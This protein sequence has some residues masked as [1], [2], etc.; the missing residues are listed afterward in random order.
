[1]IVI[2][3]PE[4]KEIIY[5]FSIDYKAT[6]K[7]IKHHIDEYNSNLEKLWNNGANK[8][9]FEIKY[10]KGQTYRKLS[11]KSG[12][13]TTV[14]MALDLLAGHLLTNM[15]TKDTNEDFR[16]SNKALVTKKHD[17]IVKSTA[18]RHVK[19]ALGCG[20]FTNKKFN[21]TKAGYSISWNKNLLRFNQNFDFN[22]VLVEQYK[23]L[24]LQQNIEAPINSLKGLYA[25]K[26]KGCDL[27]GLGFSVAS[28]NLNYTHLLLLEHKINIQSG[29]VNIIFPD[30]RQ[31][32]SI[33]NNFS[34]KS[35]NNECHTDTGTSPQVARAPHEVTEIL[36]I[37]QICEIQS[38]INI[39]TTAVENAE[40][41]KK[42]IVKAVDFE[43]ASL[44]DV[45]WHH[46][47]RVYAFA[48]TALY[49]DRTLYEIDRNL[50]CLQIY[51]QFKRAIQNSKAEDVRTSVAFHASDFLSRILLTKKYLDKNPF[52]NQPKPAT[53]FDV[54][55]N[56]CFN[57]TA[58]WLT[59]TNKMQEKNKE[60]LSHYKL[61]IS[62]YNEYTKNPCVKTF[63]SGQSRLSK[64]K[65]KVWQNMFNECIVN[66]K[67]LNKRQGMQNIRQTFYK[68]SA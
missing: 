48:I 43:N 2:P 36:E 63:Q 67:D 61:L 18:F 26:I 24:L 21:G 40:Q 44:D 65:N 16:I 47:F 53:Y 4:P 31:E 46:V 15:I 33:N 22:C 51:H 59:K 12:E 49:P 35:L 58:E 7:A 39:A 20:L 55:S 13:E 25:L 10:G 41:R 50:G 11:F 5:Y 9:L 60:Y 1:M 8:A 37:P 30:S 6:K 42:S 64:L 28:C 38:K 54:N 29:I 14:W 19:K 62:C 27:S 3:S 23:A 56:F 68:A 66:I 34:E 52:F 32:I 57:K 17:R 45:I